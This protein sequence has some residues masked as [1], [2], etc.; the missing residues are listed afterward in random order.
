M[1][2]QQILL[3]LHDP[4]ETKAI[5]N[6][7]MRFTQRLLRQ[8]CAIEN[9]LKINNSSTCIYNNGVILLCENVQNEDMPLE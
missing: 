9:I 1:D 8:R 6:E 3:R 4:N 2:F 5:H 7:Q